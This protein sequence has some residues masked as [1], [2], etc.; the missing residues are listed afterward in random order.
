MQNDW[1]RQRG[2]RSTAISVDEFARRYGLAKEE[3]ERLFKISGPSETDLRILMAAKG[4]PPI[5]VSTDP[6]GG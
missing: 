2:Q 4:I 3:A 5:S 6:V 1:T